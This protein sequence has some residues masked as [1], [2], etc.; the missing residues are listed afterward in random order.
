MTQLIPFSSLICGFNALVAI[1]CASLIW[2]RRR[3]LLESDSLVKRFYFAFIYSAAQFSL[4]FLPGTLVH[5]PYF[6]QVIYTFSDVTI[7]LIAMYMLYIPLNTFPQTQKLKQFLKTASGIVFAFSIFYVAYNLWVLK[8]VTLVTYGSMIDWRN[9]IA[10]ALQLIAVSLCAIF[11]IA[12]I[13]IFFFRGWWHEDSF[14]RKRSRILT[15][16]FFSMLL[17]WISI[18]IFNTSTPQRPGII[19]TGGTVGCG[20]MSL[21]FVALL[22]AILSKKEKLA[23]EK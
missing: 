1:F 20:V 6:I 11:I 23:N 13:L 2:F 4:N 16:G 18:S 22:W 3:D 19:L 12:T 5:D 10:P 8:P 14:I 7:M 15:V 21:G 9:S 17:G